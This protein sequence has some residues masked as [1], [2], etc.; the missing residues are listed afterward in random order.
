MTS[1]DKAARGARHLH[2]TY[3]RRAK[4]E[5]RRTAVESRATSLKGHGSPAVPEVPNNGRRKDEEPCAGSEIK[6]RPRQK[7]A[8]SGRRDEEEKDTRDSQ[9]SRV[10]R[11]RREPEEQ[12]GKKPPK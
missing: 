2:E 8:E 4:L 11:Q 3:R 7:R 9:K 1:G 12:A 10:L 5:Q 6:P